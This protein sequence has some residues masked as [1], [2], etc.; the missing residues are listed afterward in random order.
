MAV[1]MK[2]TIATE[3][4]QLAARRPIDK[5]TVK[6]LVERCGISRQTFYYH[7]QD[8]LEVMEWVIQQI[9]QR[10]L[11]NSLQANSPQKAIE[12]FIAVS[13]EHRELLMR[14]LFSQRRAQVEHIFVQAMRESVRQMIFRQKPDLAVDHQDLEVALSFYTYAIAG[15]VFENSQNSGIGTEQLAEKLCRLLSGQ[16][17]RLED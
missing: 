7:F 15:V 11:A 4:A 17:F 2:T 8:L 9:I 14:L 1:D 10:A 16:M 6:E 5:I 13:L 3:F 12:E